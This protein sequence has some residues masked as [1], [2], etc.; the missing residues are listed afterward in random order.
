M[1]DSREAPEAGAGKAAWKPLEVRTLGGVAAA[2]SGFR[3]KLSETV[4]YNP[5]S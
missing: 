3:V 2:Q 4:D 1:S 5:I